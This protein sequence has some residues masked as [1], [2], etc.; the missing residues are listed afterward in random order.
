MKSRQGFISNS[1]SS[2]F[3]VQI[4]ILRSS[5]P[6]LSEEEI[7]LLLSNGFQWS[8]V[9]DPAQV[10]FSPEGS[11]VSGTPTNALAVQV[12]C[13]EDDVIEL[14]VANNIP[15]TGLTHYGHN[16]VYFKRD[17]D[18]YYVSNKGLECHDPTEPNWFGYIPSH[19]RVKVKDFLA[20]QGTI[21]KGD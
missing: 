18:I 2:S 21:D 15:F 11:W 5:D 8:S 1:S 16:S 20:E 3:V 12:I 19:R 4:R 7:N 6:L 10:E 14:L 9:Y 13:N 17:G